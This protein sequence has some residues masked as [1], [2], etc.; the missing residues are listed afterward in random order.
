[1]GLHFP[2]QRILPA[3]LFLSPSLWY[4]QGVQL[5]IWSSVHTIKHPP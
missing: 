5:L 4:R 2:L 1:M 3:E